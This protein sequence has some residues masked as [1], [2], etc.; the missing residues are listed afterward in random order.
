MDY[1][2]TVFD[3]TEESFD[4]FIENAKKQVKFYSE[5]DAADEVEKY[6]ID[7][8]IYRDLADKLSGVSQPK[9][10]KNDEKETKET[11]NANLITNKDDS[12]DAEKKD[13]ESATNDDQ[14]IKEIDENDG[15]KRSLSKTFV[16]QK[17]IGM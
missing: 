16:S 12:K 11:A 14:K 1:C 3:D 7:F 17:E 15:G 8:K 6:R 5:K 10:T 9:E 13:S 2:K 4:K